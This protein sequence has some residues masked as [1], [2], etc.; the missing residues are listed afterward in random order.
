M[1]AHDSSFIN[2]FESTNPSSTVS[3]YHY[4]QARLS[5]INFIEIEYVGRFH[6]KK[7]FYFIIEQLDDGIILSNKESDLIAFGKTLENAKADLATEL[8]MVWEEIAME[9]DSV[10]DE[11]ACSRKRWLLDNVEEV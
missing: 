6:F 7:P 5:T 9:D 11:V 4:S 2:I 3:K 1:G 8:E 10:M